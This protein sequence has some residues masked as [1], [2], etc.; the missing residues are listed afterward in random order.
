[1]PEGSDRQPGSDR[2]DNAAIA[3]VDPGRG[4]ESR[5][6]E[7]DYSEVE[8]R[9]ASGMA[10]ATK[11]H[12]LEGEIV[13]DESLQEY[14]YRKVG[15]EAVDEREGEVITQDRLPSTDNSSSTA[16]PSH[17]PTERN[18]HWEGVI[19]YQSYVEDRSELPTE[20]QR[21]ESSDWDGIQQT[22]TT[23]RDA[24]AEH[25][26][27]ANFGRRTSDPDFE[28]GRSTETIFSR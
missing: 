15:S 8:A 26:S 18:E 1:M 25:L 21:V 10:P 27:A 11:E 22:R 12:G 20:H 6:E 16:V 4:V 28:L 5:T 14:A 3:E 13:S 7:Q 19:H 24:E 17:D 2:N 23:E 9:P